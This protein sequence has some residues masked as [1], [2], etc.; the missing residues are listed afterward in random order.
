[1]Y[2]IT[3]DY[4]SICRGILVP[5]LNFN[6]LRGISYLRVYPLNSC[7][8]PIMLNPAVGPSGPGHICIAATILSYQ[9]PESSSSILR[10]T[11]I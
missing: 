3:I 8:Y 1:M 10:L 4:F 2:A 9:L 5:E 7:I 11:S 6:K